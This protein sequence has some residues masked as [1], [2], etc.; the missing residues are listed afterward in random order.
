MC[1]V[2]NYIQLMVEVGNIQI[3]VVSYVFKIRYFFFA[4]TLL[5]GIFKR[6]V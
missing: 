2:N 4:G 3:I 6:T 1:N 5:E